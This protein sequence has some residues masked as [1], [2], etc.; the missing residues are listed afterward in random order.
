VPQVLLATNVG[1]RAAT[2]MFAAVTALLAMHSFAPLMTTI[3]KQHQ[4]KL[5]IAFIFLAKQGGTRI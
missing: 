2:Q 4:Q 3:E 5:Q 1:K